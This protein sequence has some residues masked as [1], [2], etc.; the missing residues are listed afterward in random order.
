MSPNVKLGVDSVT[1]SNTFN[2]VGG[3]IFKREIEIDN[4]GLT[5]KTNYPIRL[6][7]DH[8]DWHK[9][10]KT[11]W[12]LN[13]LRAYDTDGTTRLEHY[14]EG[15]NTTHCTIY[16]K[17]PSISA[18]TKTIYIEY[19]NNALQDLRSL[20]GVFGTA[21]DKKVT[22]STKRALIAHFKANDPHRFIGGAMKNDNPISSWVNR[23]EGGELNC[24]VN[25]SNFPFSNV[26]FYKRN[27][28]ASLP[29]IDFDGGD[30]L[31]A[32]LS[33]TYQFQSS[34]ELTMFEVFYPRTNVTNAQRLLNYQDQDYIY[35]ALTGGTTLDTIST[36]IA[37]HW[38]ASGLFI[39]SN[40]GGTTGL[41]NGVVA[42]EWQINSQHFT[43][44]ATNGMRTYRNGSLVAQRHTTSSGIAS[45]PMNTYTAGGETF[46]VTPRPIIGSYIA[47]SEYFN[48]Q[49][50]DL[51]VFSS[52]LNNSERL[53]V[54]TYLNTKYQVYGTSDMPTITVGSESSISN[55]HSLTSYAHLISFDVMSKL[56]AGVAESTADGKISKSIFNSFA[57]CL[58]LQ[59]WTG[60]GSY[61]TE[62]DLI[63][64]KA[65]KIAGTTTAK[66]D[67]VTIDRTIG[68]VNYA[69]LD[70]F[71][72]TNEVDASTSIAS[73]DDDYIIFQ[74]KLSNATN[75]NSTDTKID[76]L[77]TS[78]TDNYSAPI[79]ASENGAVVDGVNIIKIK[80]SAFTKTG[81]IT[82]ADVKKMK[83]TV[84]TSTST[85][86]FTYSGFRLEMNYE[87]RPFL[88]AGAVA[89][90]GVAV[91]S[92]DATTYYTA[93]ALP[94]RIKRLKANE[95]SYDIQMVDP[96][97]ALLDKH[98]YELP[99][100]P[101]FS[102]LYTSS[103]YSYTPSE[104]REGY[105]TWAVTKLLLLALPSSMID[106]D[107]DLPST[108]FKIGSNDAIDL[109]E[110]LIGWNE[111]EVFG[112]VLRRYLDA[113]GGS[114]AWSHSEG[115]YIART[116]YVTKSDSVGTLQTP[117]VPTVI[118]YKADS[119]AEGSQY[120]YIEADALLPMMNGSLDLVSYGRG[121]GF[122]NSDQAI[123][124]SSNDGERSVTFHDIRDITTNGYK[125]KDK[126][127]NIYR[128]SYYLGGWNARLNFTDTSF[129]NT[130][131][132]PLSFKVA[133]NGV[134]I[135]EWKNAGSARPIVQL[136]MG[137]NT[138]EYI[139]ITNNGIIFERMTARLEDSANTYLNGVIQ[140]EVDPR[141]ALVLID[142]TASSNACQFSPI[143]QVLMD[144][145]NNTRRYRVDTLYS[146]YLYPGQTV[147]VTD[148]EGKIITAF[149]VEN[150]TFAESKG[151]INKLLIESIS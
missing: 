104:W 6:V 78:G 132:V 5:S 107:L 109:K 20:T 102:C 32:L 114:I 51:L 21:F 139:P 28:V 50:G 26:P 150:Q 7:I 83:I 82:W 81:T 91:S 27:Q 65:R 54:E 88:T 19:G 149:V 3:N 108:E 60:D 120:N 95:D 86:D 35:R 34:T 74:V 72:L 124:I 117:E 29:A 146:P 133:K 30:T 46:V 112:D 147:N 43:H 118:D 99:G 31:I 140:K 68:S 70:A 97:T 113:V 44:N 137:W 36:F 106:I 87:S 63:E 148:K 119:G 79:S 121:F 122:G 57:P 58:S 96:L 101:R 103:L 123:S 135:I 10:N 9:D 84:K 8:E 62:G 14:V 4:T 85:C 90:L 47:S 145:E 13:S 2:V 141:T 49:V 128:E 17:V 75:I 64:R 127:I 39:M 151:Y 23:A 130:A 40:S 33:S 56:K 18:T 22:G 41:S 45:T 59:S 52:D 125:Y 48:G 16:I 105:Y 76:F 69:R 38:G 53:E 93:N 94:A 129:D 142:Y 144:H 138:V 131:C 1:S 98:L 12:Q 11:A 143:S 77:K 55:A 25:L 24:A 71:N 61:V 89:E 15:D 37:S 80:K 67:E 134:L 42:N 136:S 110:Y 100:M 111:F 66:T 115:K 92:D 126:A 116:A 73:T